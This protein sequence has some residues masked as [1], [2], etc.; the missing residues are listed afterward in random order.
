MKKIRVISIAIMLC[1]G[2]VGAASAVTITSGPNT[3]ANAGAIDTFLAATNTLANS[4]PATET[5]W[6]KS[7]LAALVPPET[8]TFQVKDEPVNYYTTDTAGVYAFGPM[9]PPPSE[10]FLVKNARGWALFRNLVDLAWG[11]FNTADLPSYMNLPSSSFQISHVTRFNPTAVPEPSTV[12]L[13]GMG[14]IG[15]AGICRK[16]LLK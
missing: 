15:V 12:I 10:F 2:I 5:A 8:A 3:G 1:F 13:L 11:V 6:V 4:N 9:M 7:V 14:L 16:K